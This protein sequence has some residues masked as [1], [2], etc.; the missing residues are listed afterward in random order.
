MHSILMTIALEEFER[1]SNLPCLVF[2]VVEIDNS[3]GDDDYLL[4]T[5]QKMLEYRQLAEWKPDIEFTCLLVFP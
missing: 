1:R 5:Y 3:S 2:T 4:M